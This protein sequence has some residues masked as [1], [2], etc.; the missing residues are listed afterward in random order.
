MTT[1]RQSKTTWDQI[2]IDGILSIDR[3]VAEFRI[4][5]P[6]IPSRYFRVKITETNTNRYIGRCNV[7]I[8]STDNCPEWILGMGNS[9]DEALEDTLQQFVRSLQQHKGDRSFLEEEDFTWADCEDF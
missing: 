8:N 3:V 7:S 9:I 5:S 1:I 2:A 6:D 4:E